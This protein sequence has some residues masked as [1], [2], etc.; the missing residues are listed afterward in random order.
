MLRLQIYRISFILVK[1][2]LVNNQVKP[3][4]EMF[5]NKILPQKIAKFG[6]CAEWPKCQRVKMLVG[7]YWLKTTENDPSNFMNQIR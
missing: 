7:I 6:V 3:L 4:T 5:G 2:K 1:F